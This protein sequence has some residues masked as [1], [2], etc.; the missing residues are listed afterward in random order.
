MVA[1]AAMGTPT[2]TNDRKRPRNTHRGS[3]ERAGLILKSGINGRMQSSVELGLSPSGSGVITHDKTRIL[4]RLSI[5]SVD[6][7]AGLAGSHADTEA[8]ASNQQ[9]ET[10]FRASQLATE[11]ETAGVDVCRLVTLGTVT[12][13]KMFENKMFLG[14]AALNSTVQE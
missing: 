4:S 6:I 13:P 11:P 3:G 12:D 7:H 10:D 8:N 2:D 14:A 9:V 5:H 1:E